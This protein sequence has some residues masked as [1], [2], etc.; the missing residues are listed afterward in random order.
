MKRK[1]NIDNDILLVILDRCKRNITEYNMLDI[2]DIE[3]LLRKALG[4]I[5]SKKDLY[6]RDINSIK[7][8]REDIKGL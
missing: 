7:Q 2:E 8:I 3:F 1:C 4:G 5:E 6:A